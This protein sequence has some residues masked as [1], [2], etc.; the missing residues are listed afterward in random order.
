MKTRAQ[1][2][3]RQTVIEYCRLHGLAPFEVSGLYDLQHDCSRPFPN[4]GKPGVYAIFSETGVYSETGEGLYIGKASLRNKLGPRLCGH[5]IWNNERTM[6]VPTM[7]RWEDTPPRYVQTIA[8]RNPYEAPSLEEYL[9][10]KLQPQKNRSGVYSRI[11][12]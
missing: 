4:C 3:L 9:L 1:I 5:F 6:L 2:K 8:T 10:L 11:L 12:Q 7:K